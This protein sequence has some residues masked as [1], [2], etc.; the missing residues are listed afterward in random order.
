MMSRSASKALRGTGRP[1]FIEGE[2]EHLLAA[3]HSAIWPRFFQEA[4]KGAAFAAGYPA[5]RVT[6]M[7]VAVTH[8]E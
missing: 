7:R 1:P 4:T 3:G 5:S 8:G 2:P 6:V